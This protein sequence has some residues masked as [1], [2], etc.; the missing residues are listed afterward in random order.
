MNRNAF[1]VLLIASLPLSGC[2]GGGTDPTPTTTTT[3]A[4]AV[5]RADI[6]VEVLGFAAV[7]SGQGNLFAIGLRM[8]ERAGLGANINFIRLE[9][10]RATGEFEERQ[11]I[12]ANDLIQQTGSNRLEARA[13]RELNPVVFTFGATIKKGRTLQVTVGFTDDRGNRIDIVGRFVFS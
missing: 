9:V 8:T 2:G 7:G 10:F 11:E 4:P 12:G 1:A 3:S 5:S 13:T 6:S